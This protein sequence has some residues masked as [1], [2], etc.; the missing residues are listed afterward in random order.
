M[1]LGLGE[2]HERHEVLLEG[3]LEQVIAIEVGVDRVAVIVAVQRGD[4]AE[5]AVAV[6]EQGAGD[7]RRV[8]RPRGVEA[9][10]VADVRVERGVER[11]R[12]LDAGHRDH[13]DRADLLA[14]ADAGVV[15]DGH[16]AE[17]H[18]QRQPLPVDARADLVQQAIGELL[19]ARLEHVD[20]VLVVE[21]AVE[22][23]AGRDVAEPQAERV[24]IAVGATARLEVGRADHAAEVLL[25]RELQRMVR[26]DDAAQEQPAAEPA[27]RG[28]VAVGRQVL[29]P[30]REQVRAVLEVAGLG[31]GDGRGPVGLAGVAGRLEPEA[32]IGQRAGADLEHQPE[33][34]RG[35]RVGVL[36]EHVGHD[37]GLEPELR[38]ED[39]ALADLDPGPGDQGLRVERIGRIHPRGRW[40][41]AVVRARRCRER[42][43]PDDHA[44]ADT[45]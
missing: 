8:A 40:G 45:G 19:G 17:H 14:V 22:R 11:E 39:R 32:L 38:L 33:Q 36:V 21:I 7:Q 2:H 29:I 35:D 37:A 6:A 5:R 15:A 31:V 34:A 20:R 13:G 41:D 44:E 18:G 4:P 12:G 42:P 26:I 9:V 25:K 27:L 1:Q 28:H 24:E 3:E 30:G 43:G 16:I 23:A 10:G